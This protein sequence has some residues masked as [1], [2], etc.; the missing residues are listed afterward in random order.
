MRYVISILLVI[1]SSYANA[2]GY[3][4]ESADYF[5][6]N[7]DV[8]RVSESKIHVARKMD[9]ESKLEIS[10]GEYFDGQI[11]KHGKTQ[12]QL[13]TITDNV[14][15]IGYSYM[16]DASSFGGSTEACSGVIIVK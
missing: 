9:G 12:Y 10:I 1:S 8:S 5:K 7:F 16:L 2:E 14:I 4:D 15:K 3:C 11:D 6:Y 13:I